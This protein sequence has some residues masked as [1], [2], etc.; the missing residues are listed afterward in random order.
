MYYSTDGGASWTLA[1]DIGLLSPTG[2]MYDLPAE[3]EPTEVL[4]ELWATGYEP[5]VINPPV[6]EEPPPP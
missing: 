6:E 1:T 2:F 3:C 5:D 4:W